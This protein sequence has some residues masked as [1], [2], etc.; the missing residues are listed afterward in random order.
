MKKVHGKYHYHEEIMV[1]SDSQTNLN[2]LKS[3]S[4]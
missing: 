2:I 3:F 1:Q 4:N